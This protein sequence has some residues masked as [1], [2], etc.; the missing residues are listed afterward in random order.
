MLSREVS[1]GQ[2]DDAPG[3]YQVTGTNGVAAFTTIHPGW[4]RGRTVHIHFKIRTP[5]SAALAEQ[6][7]RTYE[8]TSQLFFDD[9]LNDRVFAHAPYAGRGQR[10]TTNARDGIF[11]DSGGQLMLSVA[12]SGAG[13]KASFDVGLDL[14]NTETGKAERSDFSE[15]M[16]GPFGGPGGRRGPPPAGRPG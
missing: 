4:Y 14:A 12:P 3:G 5:A 7:D 16:G 9:A 15:G 6:R 13:Y 10:D 8:F 1:D 11:R 2:D